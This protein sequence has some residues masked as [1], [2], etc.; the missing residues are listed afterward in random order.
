MI[1]TLRRGMRVVLPSGNIIVLLRR[2][3]MQWVCEY[4]QVARA[5]G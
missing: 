4:T 1:T 3:R 5:R 2:E